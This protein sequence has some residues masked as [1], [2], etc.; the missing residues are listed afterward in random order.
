MVLSSCNITH[1]CRRLYYISYKKFC[2][3]YH[4]DQTWNN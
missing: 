4:I 2:T 3:S 1:S